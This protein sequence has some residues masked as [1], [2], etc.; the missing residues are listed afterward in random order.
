MSRDLCDIKKKRL[1]LTIHAQ[2]SSQ[3]KNMKKFLKINKIKFLTFVHNEYF[4][5]RVQVSRDISL[6]L[7]LIFITIDTKYVLNDTINMTIF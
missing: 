7:D 6:Y 1:F 5:H 2:L 4:F 3:Y